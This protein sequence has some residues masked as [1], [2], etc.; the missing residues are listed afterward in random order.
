MESVDFLKKWLRY[1][2]EPLYQ[3]VIKMAFN[4]GFTAKGFTNR[5]K[6][7]PRTIISGISAKSN[8]K[9]YKYNYEVIC[10]VIK[11][12]SKQTDADESI[13]MAQSWLYDETDRDKIIKIIDSEL[14]NEIT[15]SEKSLK[16]TKTK[17][18]EV[19]E[20]SDEKIKNYV[21]KIKELK[22]R[23]NEKNI[24]NENLEND[25]RKIQKE[26]NKKEQ[27]ILELNSKI[28]E[29]KQIHDRLKREIDNKNKKIEELRKDNKKLIEYKNNVSRILCIGIEALEDTGGFNIVFESI[30]NDEVKKRYLDEQY[31]EVWIVTNCLEYYEIIEIKNFFDCKICEYENKRALYESIRR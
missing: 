8:S 22:K 10:E 31:Y 29:L 1:I 12:L 24:I 21:N 17:N 14:N 23:I 27:Q 25:K 15:V 19:I 5:S 18:V 28:E 11:E 4:R 2:D 20:N 30:W 26:N 3:K 13:N 9:V 6:N 7:Y 16:D